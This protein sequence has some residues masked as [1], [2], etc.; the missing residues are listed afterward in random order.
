MVGGS[1]GWS[2]PNFL[3]ESLHFPRSPVCLV[4]RP[5]Y[6]SVLSA[7]LCVCIF[8]PRSL[9][10]SLFPGPLCVCPLGSLDLYSCNSWVRKWEGVLSLLPSMVTAFLYF[11]YGAA[12]E[13]ASLDMH[14]GFKEGYVYRRKGE[15]RLQIFINT[16]FFSCPGPSMLWNTRTKFLLWLMWPW[17]FH[18][19]PKGWLKIPPSPP[20]FYR[21][22]L[23]F[24][25]DCC[26]PLTV[27]C[28]LSP[29]T[30]IWN[31][32]IYWRVVFLPLSLPTF[33]SVLR[34]Q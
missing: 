13:D 15:P 8:V 4:P 11:L 1:Q 29:Q 17:L 28:F 16:N 26:S 6:P 33:L 2:F 7:G 27:T 31:S 24:P 34:V 19:Q 21:S 25:Q 23:F 5:I 12:G 18:H 30:K 9:Y 3:H 22:M 14:K 20:F 10:F 32:A